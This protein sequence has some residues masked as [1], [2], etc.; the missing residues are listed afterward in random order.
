MVNIN[1]LSLNKNKSKYMICHMPNKRI[2]TF[3]LKIDDINIERVDE[4]NFLGLTLDT[5]L[6]W[7]KTLKKSQISAPKCTTFRYKSAVI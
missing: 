4:L 7:K 1:T 2:H 5:D 3:T 6:N